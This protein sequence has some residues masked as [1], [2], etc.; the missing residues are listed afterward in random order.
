MAGSWP[1]LDAEDLEARV[2]TYLN[3]ATA[4]FYSQVEIWRWLSLAAKDIAQ[5]TLCVRRILDAVTSNAIRNVATNAYK[6]I[7]V[8]Y[9][10]ATGRPKMLTKIDPLRVGHYPMTGTAPQYWFEFGSNIGIDPLPNDVYNLR[11]YVADLPKMHI[12]TFT[13]F[14]EGAGATAWTDSGTGWTCGATAAHA[15]GTDTLTYN[16]ALEVAVNHTYVFTVAGAGSVTPYAGT[17]AGIACAT[18]GVHM[19]TL[20]TA[21]GGELKF[22]GA[23]TVSI[24]NLYVYKE[25]DFAATSDQTELPTMWQHL[26]A[27][28]ATHGGLT[29]DKKQGPAQMLEAIYLNE[30]AYL[31]QN[32]VEVIP[33]GRTSLKYQ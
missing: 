22:S 33:D 18:G 30:L 28:Y 3:E 9:L 25:R 16:T 29:K 21:G 12:L 8:E 13:S 4:D 15:G 2:R 14:T 5:R 32:V 23:G 1:N 31:R 20:V 11:L 6:V 24:D 7:H 27:L 19:Q 17:T 10:P 26:L